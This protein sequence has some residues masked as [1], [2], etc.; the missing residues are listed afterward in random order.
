MER[1]LIGEYEALVAR[2]LERLTSETH[3]DAVAVLDL[4]S[5]I[6]GYGPV[7]DEAVA[8]YHKT[9]QG[10]EAALASTPHDE[11]PRRMALT[12]EPS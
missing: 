11:T 10:L 9:L 2:T 12:L 1:A 3:A 4:A 7:K 5:A 6:R 8:N